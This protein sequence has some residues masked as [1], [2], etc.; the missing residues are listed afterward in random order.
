MRLP[1]V[2]GVT[3]SYLGVV[4]NSAMSAKCVNF[5]NSPNSARERGLV[6][7]CASRAGDYDS[8]VPER[9]LTAPPLG[10]SPTVTRPAADG[11]CMADA[12]CLVADCHRKPL[13]ARHPRPGRIYRHGPRLVAVGRRQERARRVT[14]SREV[15]GLLQKTR[16]LHR[17]PADT[18][19]SGVRPL[20]A[21]T[22]RLVSVSSANGRDCAQNRPPAGGVWDLSRDTIKSDPSIRPPS[23]APA[24]PPAHHRAATGRRPATDQ[25]HAEPPNQAAPFSLNRP[26][27][28]SRFSA[29]A[30]PHN[31]F[32]SPGE[33]GCAA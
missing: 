5:Y 1:E 21:G 12:A 17:E 14:R 11:R 20:R 29:I 25:G 13:Q 3:R 19:A 26:R 15:A 33:R 7:R 6:Q 16:E 18:G 2:G 4:G 24:T 27:C 32:W 30:H 31:F 10:M 8:A 22:G 9:T 28:L 23:A